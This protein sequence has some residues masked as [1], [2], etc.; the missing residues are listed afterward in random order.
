MRQSKRK[1]LNNKTVSELLN[2]IRN[3]EF[4]GYNFSQLELKK[5]IPLN[6]LETD[7]LIAKYYYH[8]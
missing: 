4:L 6:D 2:L 3:P 8:N 5:C 7:I 1:T